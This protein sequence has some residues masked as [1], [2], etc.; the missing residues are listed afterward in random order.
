MKIRLPWMSRAD[1]TRWQAAHTLH[2][3]G[4]LTAA[5]LEG[6]IQSRPGYQP[7]YGPDDETLP[8]VQVLATANHGGYLTHGSQPGLLT[9][10]ANS[11][12]WAQRA[13]VDGFVS[14]PVVLRRLIDTAEKAGLEVIVND[15]LDAQQGHGPGT[16]VTLRDGEGHTAFGRALGVGDLE[17]MW[18]GFPKAIDTAARALQVTLADPD[19]GPSTRLWEV[20]AEAT[21]RTVPGSPV[22]AP[23]VLC[24][25]GCT[26]IDW[27]ICQ[28]GCRGVT[29]QTAG[30]CEACIDPS[31][32]ID[33]S[34]EL[35]DVTE[36]ECALCGAPYYTARRYCSDA[37]EIADRPEHDYVSPDDSLPTPP[38]PVLAWPDEQPF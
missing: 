8:H 12:H 3:L 4:Q 2:D 6:T 7:R 20:L 22:P 14:D 35:D 23:T 28:D 15:L 19:F 18:R 32:I 5:W 26:A 37:C 27:Q 29:N 17:L 31:V 33:W 36:T 25:C 24:E 9:T 30:R 38:L 34:K 1:R 16:V 10:D 13:A 11:T 21:T